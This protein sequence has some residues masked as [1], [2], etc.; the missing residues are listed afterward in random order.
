MSETVNSIVIQNEGYY[1]ITLTM[2]VDMEGVSSED[3]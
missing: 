1:T 3:W 2:S